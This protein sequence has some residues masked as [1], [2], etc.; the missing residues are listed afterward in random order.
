MIN[1]IERFIAVVDE[2]TFTKASKKLFLTQPA[3]SLSVERLEKA[4]GAKLFK[5]IG[6]RLVLTKDGESVYRIGL[7]ILKLWRKAKDP[8]SREDSGI[9][10]YS[11]G[12][13]DNAA[14]ILS[15]YF[16]KT[17]S[18][19]NYKFEITIDR[20]SSLIKGMQN[21]IYD[22]CICIINQEQFP[23]ANCVLLK[24]FQEKLFPVSSKIWKKNVSEIP[25]ILYNARSST[26]NYIDKVFL[27]NG[28]KPSVI[29][30]STSPSFMKEL[31]IGNCGVTL[32][33]KNFIKREIQQKKLKIQKFPFTF[34]R[35]IGLFLSKDSN[36]KESDKI[37]ED[38]IKNLKS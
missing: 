8:K 10:S 25:F 19:N 28:I 20:S 13:F 6:K 18:Q 33:P 11:I 34:E 17:F 3:L 1:E 7:Q 37:I 31:A 15:K 22:V 36:L 35:Q 21:G 29:V 26:R 27:E 4:I 16:Q 14:L 2:G 9:I 12:I 32:L 23:I 24:T 30:E 5:Q 38:L